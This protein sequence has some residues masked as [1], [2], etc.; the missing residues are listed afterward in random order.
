MN[1]SWHDFL[2]TCHAQFQ[3][4]V[5]QHFGDAAGELAAAQDGTVLCDLGQFGVLKVTGE[6]AQSFL[7]NLLSSNVKDVTSSKAQLSSF[8]TAKGRML[9]TFLI[10]QSGAD[11][12]LRL[13]RSLS[14]AMQ[15]KLSMYVLRSKVKIA[16]AS[17]EL[18]CLGL[19][20]KGTNTL[21]R[22]S[23]AAVPEEAMGVA[24]SA[25][26]S[27]IRLDASRLLIVTT[28]G[29]APAL[30]KSLNC[31]ARAAG[32]PCWDWLDIRAG[33]PVILPA[34]QE[35][36]V[37]Q[38]ANLELIGAVN[39]KK[40]CY[41][42]QEI[43]ARMQY[44]GRLKQRMYLAHVPGGAAPQPGEMLYS[45]D[46]EGQHSGTVVNAAPAPGGGY[47][48]LAVV[49][50]SSRESQTVHLGGLQG[51]TLEFQQLPYPLS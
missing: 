36:F 37:P 48:L 28:P 16:D 41:P 42:G 50:I 2:S 10:W 21:A 5:V 38:M 23:F 35:Q 17:D 30:W 26:A 14:A 7:Q 6:D 4:G 27:L 18:V 22:E 45:A 20:G 46:M 13:P 25:N 19:A 8:N 1:Q 49:Q 32:A 51:A 9:A 47:D 24:V 34:T 29:Q 3:D 40:G 39:F 12:F 33:I 11:Y 43:V 15:K 31:G 44:L